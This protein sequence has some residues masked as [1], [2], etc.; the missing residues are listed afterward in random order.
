MIQALEVLTSPA[1]RNVAELM[2]QVGA[3]QLVQI[4][5][6]YANRHCGHTVATVTEQ[7]CVAPTRSSLTA[8]PRGV[9]IF[10]W[11]HCS[12]DTLL[13]HF[14]TTGPGT[15]PKTLSLLKDLDDVLELGVS[16]DKSRHDAKTTRASPLAEL[17]AG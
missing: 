15:I 17:A 11:R 6:V 5:I 3:F 13:D 4:P 2:R 8:R 1:D 14:P 16:E 9:T 7:E 10:I 12:R